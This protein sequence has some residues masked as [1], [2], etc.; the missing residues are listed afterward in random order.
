MIA[1]VIGMTMSVS[2]PAQLS[3]YSDSLR[4]GRCGDRIP[5]GAIFS[6]CVHTGPGADPASYTMGTRFLSWG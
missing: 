5:V 6:A 2:S 4:A 1:T 3:R